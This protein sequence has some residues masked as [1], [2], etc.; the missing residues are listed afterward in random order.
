MKH[1]ILGTMML[2]IVPLSANAQ[3]IETTTCQ[4]ESHEIANAAVSHLVNVERLTAV[5]M[6]KAALMI[7]QNCGTAKLV[8]A[9]SAAGPGTRPE[10][11]AAI[12]ASSL[13]SE[14]QAWHSIAT[15][16]REASDAALEAALEAHPDSPL[17]RYVEATRAG[18]PSAYQTYADA[19]PA[20]S[21]AALNSLA[22]A[23]SGGEFGEENI[24]KGIELLD[25]AI[26][27]HDGPNLFDSKAEH[28]AM[29]GDY[30]SALEWQIKAYDYAADAGSGYLQNLMTYNRTI[31]ADRLR[32]AVIERAK[33]RLASVVEAGD[34]AAISF[35]TTS[36]EVSA[37]DS[38]MEPCYVMVDRL[39]RGNP[40]E[41]ERW[42]TFDHIVTF[43][44]SHNT[45][46][47]S[48]RNEGEYRVSGSDALTAYRTRASEVWIL[49]G[50]E[51]MLWHSNFAPLSGG[52]GIPSTTD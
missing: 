11:L 25:L 1:I 41:W 42:D 48:Y 44:P 18:D 40:V 24:E 39:Q 16:D 32:E 36:A 34:G 12:D 4:G 2:F 5:G 47:V 46:V 38:N 49:E 10:K 21:A 51:W 22:Y 33:G 26:S 8:M 45:A 13:S 17:F 19:Y 3:W 7:D 29:M 23:Y 31:N 20:T 30:E 37:C 28:Y 50:G 43:N 6:A 9:L 15:P 35:L 27:L 52:V 14:E